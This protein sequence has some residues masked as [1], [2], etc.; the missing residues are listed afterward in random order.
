MAQVILQ[1]VQVEIIRTILTRTQVTQ[2]TIR[3][4]AI[5]SNTGSHNHSLVYAY[6]NGSN[7]NYIFSSNPGQANYLRTT[8]NMNSSGSHSHNVATYGAGD[9]SH[10]FNANTGN[11]GTHTH[12]VTGTTGATGSGTSVTTTPVYFTLAFI[13]KS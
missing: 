6:N 4:T 9:H 12:S 5:R 11:S 10:N 8:N 3:I 2:E 7:T 1:Q 13:M